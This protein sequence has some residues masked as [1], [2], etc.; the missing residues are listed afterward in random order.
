[1]IVP[2]LLTE[3]FEGCES[4]DAASDV[5]VTEQDVS[6]AVD[7]VELD[8][9]VEEGA[10]PKTAPLLLTAEF[11]GSK[12]KDTASDVHVTEKDVSSAV[13]DVELDIPVE[14]GEVLDGAVVGT[15]EFDEVVVAATKRESVTAC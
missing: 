4:K 2:A 13:D 10:P 12:T 14:E 7:D 15:K 3:K 1:M 5:D 6:S 9:P 11:E 8:V